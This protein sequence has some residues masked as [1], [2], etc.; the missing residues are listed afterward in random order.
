[1]AEDH[2]DVLVIGAGPGGYVAA[3][4]AA[5]LGR[6]VVLV[7]RRG[8]QGLGGVCLHAGC[9][10]T[11][12][13]LRIAGEAGRVAGMRDAGLVAG[14][15]RVD[16]DAFQQWKGELTARLAVGVRRLLTSAGVEVV[17]GTCRFTGPAQVV[18]AD[19]G[20]SR[21]VAFTDAVLATGSRPVAPENLPIDGTVVLDSTA[22]LELREV[23]PSMVVVGGGSVG[24][25]L[26][27][28]FAKLGSRV[29][30]V[31]REDQ[32]LPMF[33]ATLV[34]P[35][36]RRLGQLGVEVLTGATV[37]DH[38]HGKALVRDAKGEQA[39]EATCLLA[40]VGRRP[41]TDGLGLDLAGVTTDAGG[42][43][44][45]TPALLVAEHIA[46]V[47]DVTPGPFHAHKASAQAKIAA[48]SLCGQ[49][50]AFTRRN[51]PLIVHSEPELASVGVTPT[52][53][54][55]PASGLRTATFPLGGSGW[56]V[57]SG[58][59]IGAAHVVVDD[60]ND[61]V[62]GVHLVGPHATE[63]IGEGALA[64]DAGVK[65]EDLSR[66]IHAHPTLS[67]QLGEVAH[68]ASGLPV[69]AAARPARR[70]RG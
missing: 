53:A 24:M 17:T 33:D 44:A 57:A 64:V 43:T 42:F 38:E 27:T 11:K 15:V 16:L 63:L 56:A 7:D 4:H 1:M 29:T 58:A 8:Q 70:L 39:V 12:A 49:N 35:L 41:N 46:A 37:V 13:L 18:I 14:Q 34:R 48:Q 52:E 65:L 25:E 31:E 61:V 23:P 40:G 5:H 6:R 69:H 62:V 55:E 21:S 28:T 45:P 54:R 66:T 50:V 22:A 19:G 3:L 36:Q 59:A 67:E 68:L 47:G 51:V 10:P 20:G 9:V 32:L 30:I 26:G 2:V 60:S